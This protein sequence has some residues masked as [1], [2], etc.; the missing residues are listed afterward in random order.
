[1]SHIMNSLAVNYVHCN[2]NIVR[3]V[4]SMNARNAI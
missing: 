3:V 4:H 2:V 1:M